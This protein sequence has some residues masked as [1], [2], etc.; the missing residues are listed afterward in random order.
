MSLSET[1]SAVNALQEY[2]A[3]ARVRNGVVFIIKAIVTDKY[4]YNKLTCPPKH[5]I[6]VDKP[7]KTAT[8]PPK[9]PIS[10]DKTGKTATC[11]PKHPIS[12]DKPGKTAT[13]PPKHGISVDKRGK[14]R[15]NE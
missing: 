6:S 11:P 1:G 7:G 3:A 5:P 12:V 14:E 8:Y 4:S 13:C 15:E 2:R 10:V 9:H